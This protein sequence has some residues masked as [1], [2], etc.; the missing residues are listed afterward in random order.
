MSERNV[1][2]TPHLATEARPR[3]AYKNLL[4]GI[5]QQVSCTDWWAGW[6][7]PHHTRTRIAA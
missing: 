1:V 6:A 4:I 7:Y 5:D 2:L 3:E